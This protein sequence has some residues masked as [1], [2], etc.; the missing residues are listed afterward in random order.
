V[1]IWTIEE[2]RATRMEMFLDRKAAL[3]AAGLSK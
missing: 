1:N 3:E 2:G